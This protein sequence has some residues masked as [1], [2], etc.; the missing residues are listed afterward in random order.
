MVLRVAWRLLW[1]GVLGGAVIGFVAT[2]LLFFLVGL[3]RGP[4]LQI[5][6]WMALTCWAVVGVVWFLVAVLI[7]S[8]RKISRD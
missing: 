8:S 4:V 7:S 5:P 3:L 1:L 2:G 6:A